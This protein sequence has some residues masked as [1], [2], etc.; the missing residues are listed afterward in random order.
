[1]YEFIVRS[2][3][4]IIIVLLY[5]IGLFISDYLYK[6][7]QFKFELKYILP[8]ISLAY[9]EYW[10]RIFSSNF[11]KFTLVDSVLNDNSITLFLFFHSNSKYV[12][13]FKIL[14][15][16]GFKGII[17]TISYRNSETDEFITLSMPELF[18]ANPVLSHGIIKFSLNCRFRRY[19]KAF[20]HFRNLQLFLFKIIIYF[21]LNEFK[22]K[23]RLI[24]IK[25]VKH[26]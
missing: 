18:S 1:M 16:R 20:F 9:I 26:E 24:I 11:Y 7:Y 23:K 13:Q 25:G 2:L 15:I 21:N 19:P 12:K 10:V 17:P 5:F 14:S 22:K 4:V 3:F 6:K 8:I